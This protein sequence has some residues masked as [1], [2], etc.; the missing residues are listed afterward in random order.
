MNT[1]IADGHNLGWKLAWVSRGWADETLLDS[2]QDERGPVGRRNASRS[3]ESRIGGSAESS[4]AADFGVTYGSTVIADGQ[5]GEL[6][7]DEIGQ[8]VRPG[9][10]APHAWVDRESKRLSTIDLFDGHLTLIIGAAACATGPWDS[11]TSF[12]I[13]CPSFRRWTMSPCR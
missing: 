13:C 3:M 1:G 9:A 5:T 12:I 2:Y 8:R 7:L 4:L 6:S 10:R 11:S